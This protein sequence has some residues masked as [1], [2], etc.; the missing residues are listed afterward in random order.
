MTR[1]RF[2]EF[3]KLQGVMCINKVLLLL[4]LLLLL[5]TIDS[6]TVEIPGKL[7]EYNAVESPLSFCWGLSKDGSKIFVETAW[8]DNAYN[9]ISRWRKNTF[10][11]PYGKT[12]KEFIDKLSDHINDW[13]NGV[14]GSHV[15]LKS[16]IVLMA[17]G[18]QKPHMKSKSKDHQECLAKRLTFWKEG[19][20]DTLMREGRMIQRKLSNSKKDQTPNKAKVFANL[21]M[22]GEI[23]SAIRYLCEDNGGGILPLNDDVMSQLKEKHPDAQEAHLGSLLFGPIEDI[24]DVIFQE[25]DGEMVRETALKT[26]GSGGPSGVDAN[27]FK[28]LLASKSFKRSGTNLC[29]AIATMTRKLCTEHVDP[30]SI[31][32]LVSSRLIP[33]DK[34]EGAVR[35]IGVG[36]VLRRIIGKCVTRVTKCDVIAASG[37][38]QVCAGLKSGSE[39]AVHAIRNIFEADETD[40]VLLIDAS[41]A[42]NALNRSAALHNIRVLC[43]T[44]ATYA[45]NTY[46]KPARLFVLGGKELRSVEGTTQGDPL[47]MS[48][49]AIS[50]QPL[51]T[52]LQLSSATKQCWFADDAT[53][54]GSF[55]EIRKWW[56]DL[57]INGPT[58]G[59]FPNAKKCW[60]I[61]KPDREDAGRKIFADT[62][63]NVTSEGHK[64]LG[65]ALGSRPF[66]EKY[67]GEKVEDWVQQINKLAIF[68]V[69]QPQACYAA[70]TFGLRHRWTYFLRTLPDITELLEPLERAISKLLIPSITDH[71]VTANDRVLLS[72][73]VRMGGLGFENPQQSSPLEYESSVAVT[74]PLV[75]CI[76]AQSHQPPEE[77]DMRS[78]SLKTRTKKM[79]MLD[80]K[81]EE[82]K[83]DLPPRSLK[84]V[85]LACEKGASSW[86]TVLPLRELGYNLNKQEFRD[87]IKMRYN[88]GIPDLPKVCICGDVFDIDHAMICKRGGLVIQRHNEIRDL[89]AEL[90]SAVCKDVEVEPTLQPLSGETLN[91]GANTSSDARLDIHARSF[92]ERQRSVFFDVRVCHPCADSYREQTPAQI[93]RQHESEKKRKYANRVLEVEQGTF[94]PLIFS[95]TGGMGTEC[96]MFHKRLAE[97]LSIKKNESYA[98]TMSW[99]RA[100]VSFALLRS[101]LLCLRGTRNIRKTFDTTD[102]DF[103]LENAMANIST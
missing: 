46:R 103:T 98:T 49:Y 32:A 97:L 83:T 16:A 35:P 64:H 23:H 69:S 5:I 54:C 29:N 78:R 44:L 25:I 14:E 100:K 70:F 88:W 61:T 87:A 28:R 26:K 59:Y 99:V 86:L 92:W 38:L 60:L 93:Y 1:T 76:I 19:K 18:L 31:E 34:G 79:E 96:K 57:S 41:N 30:S 67:V 37:S 65:A 2:N 89:E 81:L 90:L 94:T 85:D 10:L 47:A 82:I 3:S 33:L 102:I 53:G 101:A 52:K 11:V 24:P 27:G 71:Q 15:S 4:L 48:L 68:A 50:L 77:A 95:T 6:P 40:A 39:A 80:K 72:L 73:P 45:I 43:P 42:F 91:N 20:I 51:I 66:L 75:E 7:P 22:R 58:L 55:E 12:G 63:V 17:V 21:V 36:E 8:I 13:N 9:E 84:A 62:L 74:E 56:N